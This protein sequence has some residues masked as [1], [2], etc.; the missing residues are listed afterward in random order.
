MAASLNE[1]SKKALEAMM[2]ISEFRDRSVWFKEGE[3][4]GKLEGKLEGEKT[5]RMGALR[6]AVVDLAELLGLEVSPAP[7]ASLVSLELS[8]LE[9]LRLHLKQHRSWPESG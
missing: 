3:Q 1:V 4:R 5:G 8:G 6:E 9:S 7:R 2:S